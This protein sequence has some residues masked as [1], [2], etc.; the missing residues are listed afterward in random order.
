MKKLDIKKRYYVGVRKC[1][2]NGYYY[3]IYSQ[4]NSLKKALTDKYHHELANGGFGVIL[5]KADDGKLYPITCFDTRYDEEEDY[6]FNYNRPVDDLLVIFKNIT[7]Y[8]FDGK[9]YIEC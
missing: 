1:G 9:N 2:N 3:S 8:K 6:E 5:A 4:T 7:E